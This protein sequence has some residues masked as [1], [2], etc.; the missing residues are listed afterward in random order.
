M[1]SLKYFD[2]ALGNFQEAI[3][4]LSE[5]VKEF[6]DNI[7]ILTPEKYNLVDLARS[8]KQ[9]TETGKILTELAP[10]F[11]AKQNIEGAEHLIEWLLHTPHY[12]G[13]ERELIVGAV[14]AYQTAILQDAGFLEKEQ[15]QLL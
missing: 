10:F 7:E 1:T 11:Q 14:R 2:E 13:A 8:T 5:K 4:T 6:I 9:L 15:Y 12:V 3:S